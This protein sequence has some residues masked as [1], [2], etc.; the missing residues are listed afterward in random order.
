M[1]LHLQWEEHL[2]HLQ[3]GNDYEFGVN[4]DGDRSR[5]I[6]IKNNDNK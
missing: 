5:G 3:P 4:P 1:V 2:S 6:F